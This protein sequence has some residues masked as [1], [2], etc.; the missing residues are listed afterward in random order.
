[1]MEWMKN[2]Y[3]IFGRVVRMEVWYKEF[4]LMCWFDTTDLELVSKPNVMWNANPAKAPKGKFYVQAKIWDKA[5]KNSK[6]TMLHRHILGL[7]N[8]DL[9]GH[10]VDNNGLNNRRENLQIVNH[11][12][13]MRE[14][15]KG[16]DWA[17]LDNAR[18]VRELYQ[19]EREI[20]ANIQEKF[21]LS[22]T[23][24]YKIRA[25]KRP[26]GKG[27]DAFDAYEQAIRDANTQTLQ[28]LQEAYP[29]SGKWGISKSGQL[30]APDFPLNQK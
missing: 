15:F 9:E 23:W 20:A 24:I 3:E 28:Q 17:W 22:R 27:K 10:H 5:T 13:N 26:N 11:K 18:E 14:R 25:G 21:D 30:R 1:M 8:P 19:K 4:Q 16:R 12:K 2:Y 7:T 6:C 29:K